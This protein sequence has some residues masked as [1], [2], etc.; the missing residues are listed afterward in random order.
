MADSDIGVT[1]SVRTRSAS[2]GRSPFPA[3]VGHLH[4]AAEL[5][6]DRPAVLLASTKGGWGEMP[7]WRFQRQ[8]VRIG[9]CL[10]DRAGLEVGDR[11]ALVTRLRPESILM[12]WAALLQG[13]AVAVLDPRLPP[14]ALRARLSA[15]E[16]RAILTDEAMVHAEIPD[17]AA[18]VTIALDRDREDEALAWSEA[19]D[20]GGSLDTGERARDFRAAA[21]EISEEAPALGRWREAGPCSAGWHYLEQREL[22]TTVERLWAGAR[23]ARGDVALVSAAPS[24]AG[25]VAALAFT[26]DGVTQLAF[27]PPE[28]PGAAASLRPH[29][30][31]AEPDSVHALLRE[32]DALRRTRWLSV[33]PALDAESRARAL[34]KVSSVGAT[35]EWLPD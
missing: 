32:G 2:A 10:R 26:S 35:A 6:H 15:L 20:L 21:R 28:D 12:A 30:I 4:L 11:V 9:L 34:R 13:A 17:A 19:L 24:A 1:K 8:I 3:H 27:E 29:K 18:S 22:A 23:I 16:P 14:A 25:L 33:S 7:D 5:T 31:V